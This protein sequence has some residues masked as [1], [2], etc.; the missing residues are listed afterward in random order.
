MFTIDFAEGVADDL[1]ELRASDRVT[2]LDRIDEQLSYE[3]LLTT[4]N[5]KVLP[6]LT[7]LAR[8]AISRRI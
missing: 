5:K 7:P 8:S 4:R 3:P 2:I 6:G 1:A